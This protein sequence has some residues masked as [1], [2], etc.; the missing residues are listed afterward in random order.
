MKFEQRFF[1]ERTEKYSS[2]ELQNK[3]SSEFFS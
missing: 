3:N 1:S 2:E